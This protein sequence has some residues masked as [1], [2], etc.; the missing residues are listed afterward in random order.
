MDI[1]I[2]SKST[3][4]LGYNSETLRRGSKQLFFRDVNVFLVLSQRSCLKPSAVL[5]GRL[6]SLQD[7]SRRRGSVDVRQHEVEAEGH[8]GS[9]TERDARPAPTSQQQQQQRSQEDEE[10]R[11]DGGQVGVAPG[12]LSVDTEEDSASQLPDQQKPPKDVSS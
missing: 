12:R 8:Q 3:A 11:R 4:N 1:C 9:G 5:I 2:N 7:V 6:L 10:D